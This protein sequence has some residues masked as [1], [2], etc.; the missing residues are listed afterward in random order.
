MKRSRRPL[1]HPLAPIFWRAVESIALSLAPDTVRGYRAATRHFLNYLG[2]HHP[3]V[4]SLDQLRRDPHILGW[5]SS[6]HSETPPLVLAAYVNKLIRLRRIFEELAWL[7]QIPDL[8]HLLRREDSPRAEKCL[9][10]AFTSLQDQLIQKELLHRNDLPSNVMLLLRH[11]GMRIGECVDLPCDCLRSTGPDQWAIQV[12]LG[13]TKTERMVPVDSFVSEIVQRLRF[14]RSLDPLPADGLLL[15]RPR[16]REMLTR[17]LRRSLREIATAAGICTRIVP[18]QFRHTYATELLRAGVTLPSLMKLLG[19]SSADMTMRYLKITL[20]DLQREFH[21]ARSQPRHLMPQP[22][23][24]VATMGAG[25]PGVLES[26]HT[27][28]HVLEM[29]RRTLPDGLPRRC[30]GRLAN[31]LTKILSE[32]RK[33]A[34]REK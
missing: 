24:P 31:R 8:V 26:L 20:P 5:L 14:L 34:S 32:A 10:R 16:G 11:T 7:Q 33:L 21:L 12:P 29:F 15:A 9:P 6:L 4:S 2:A 17:E 22:K 1:V 25:L 13:K 27:S 18:H 30:L 23:A 3:E 28:Q 19:H